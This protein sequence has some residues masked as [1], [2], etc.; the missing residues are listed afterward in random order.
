MTQ[1]E[2]AEV[3]VDSKKATEYVESGMW[4]TY[5]NRSVRSFSR[6]EKMGLWSSF[7]ILWR[8]TSHIV[9]LKSVLE[10]SLWAGKDRGKYVEEKSLPT[11][12]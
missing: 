2:R 12:D 1:S 3:M 6:E 10:D 4:L 8:V 11:N 5:R 7:S 9:N